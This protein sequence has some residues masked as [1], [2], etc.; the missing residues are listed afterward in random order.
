MLPTPEEPFREALTSILSD[1]LS[2]IRLLL[3]KEERRASEANARTDERNRL[4]EIAALR[5]IANRLEAITGQ[6]NS[7]HQKRERQYWGWSVL[8]QVL[9]FLA[10]AGAFGAA[11]WYASIAR[12]QK[13]TMD[14]QLTAMNNS[15]GEIQKQTGP[16]KD[17]AKAAADGATAAQQSANVAR[18]ALTSAQRAFVI[19]G[20]NMQENTVI[21]QGPPVHVTGW[22]FRPRLQNSGTT[23]TH[24]ARNHANFQPLVVLPDNFQFQDIGAGPSDTRFALGPREDATG[25]L[26]AVPWQLVN[27][28]RPGGGTHI[29]FWGWARY[30]DIFNKTTEHISMF[31]LELLETRNLP[32][33]LGNITP[34]GPGNYFM[35]WELC[36]DKH[37]CND[38]E[39]DGEPYGNGLVWRTQR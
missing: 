25:A 18:D 23:P 5:Q 4:E 31:C 9:L 16:I 36:S 35:T 7:N 20:K 33:D 28:T 39:C 8:V 17:S 10:T 3:E 26:L 11:I 37:N 30:R 22:E 1:F 24:Y 34:N 15:F 14:G 13:T 29:F 38:D 6:Q 19:F 12:D 27:A 2:S 32:P 21:D